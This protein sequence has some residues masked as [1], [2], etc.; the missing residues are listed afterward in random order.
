MKKS[1]RKVLA[2]Q[3]VEIVHQGHYLSRTKKTVSISAAVKAAKKGTHL[4]KGG[5]MEP[6]RPPGNAGMTKIE[7][8]NESTFAALTRLASEGGHLGCLNFASAKHAGGGFLNGAEAQEE[9]LC[10]ASALYECLGAENVREY[11]I[12][13]RAHHSCLYLDLLI[14]SPNVPFFRDDDGHLIE[15]PVLSTVIT[16]AAPNAGAIH[17]N[18]PDSIPSIEPTLRRRA[19]MVLELAA[20]EGVE[21]LVLGAWGCGV[22]RN[23]PGMVADAF[24][25]PLAP[26]G[27]WHGVFKHIV[28]AV[29]DP[30]K[31]GANY[32]A[33]H[34]AF[35]V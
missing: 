24:K 33:F 27:Q 3:T 18:E 30:T 31:N 21:Y 25:T 14:A 20:N 16:A 7:V 11:Y 17:Q 10:R 15:K 5:P 6:T 4:W 22:F 32:L 13:N 8:T 1:T 23:S 29:Y 19:A 26:G 28:F 35:G 9:A 2:Q 34:G 12:R